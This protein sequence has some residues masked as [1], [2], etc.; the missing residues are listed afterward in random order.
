MQ[1]GPGRKRETSLHNR[2]TFGSFGWAWR[3][4]R[5]FCAE[6]CSAGADWRGFLLPGR[7]GAQSTRGWEGGG[8]GA[9]G[10]MDVVGRGAP[11]PRGG[12]ADREGVWGSATLLFSETGERVQGKPHR[13]ALWP[14][15]CW[16]KHA[17]AAGCPSVL[18]PFRTLPSQPREICDLS[19]ELTLNVL[20]QGDGFEPPR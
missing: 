17:A 10:Q 12:R 3:G 14:Q 16:A 5:F 13:A 4:G 11:P 20:I 7:G 19:A 1:F 15:G 18:G 9:E 6:V 2:G 8:A